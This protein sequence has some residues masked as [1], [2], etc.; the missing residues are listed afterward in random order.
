MSG[1]FYFSMLSVLLCLTSASAQSLPAEAHPSLLLSPEDIPLLKERITRAP[2]DTWWQTVLTRSQNGLAADAP[3]RSKARLAKSMAFTYLMTDENTW[4]EQALALMQNTQFPPR[5]GDMGQPHNEGELVAHYALAYDMLHSYAEANN[6]TAL[7]AVREILAEEAA[8]LEKGIVI[9]EVNL[10]LTTLKIRLHETPHLGN[11]HIRAYAGLGLAAL[12]LSEHEDAQAWAD[13]AFDLV[14][15]S[16]DYQIEEVDGGYAEGPF[17]SRYSADVYLPYMF[18]LKR[19]QGIDLFAGEKMKAMHQWSLNLR[20]PDGR[21]PNIDDSHIDDFYGHYLASVADNGGEYRWDWEHNA[22]GLY[23]RQF[24]E[25]DAIVLFDDQ[26]AATEPTREPTIFMPGAGDAVFRS[27]W[28]ETGT[29]M[30][31]RGENGVA[32]RR[33][34]SHEHPDETSF[35]LHA[36][37]EMLAL[38]AGYINFA[39]HAKVNKGSNHNVVLVDG[40][41][42]PLFTAFGEAIGGGNDA[43]IE[44]SF[45]SGNGDYAEVRAAYQNVD[46]RRR[47]FFVGKEYFLIA[48]HMSASEEH[49]YEWRLHGNGGGSSGGTYSRDGNLAR[50]TRDNAELIAYVPEREGRSFAE[51]DTIHSFAVGQELTH[52]ALLVQQRG[53]GGHYLAALFPRAIGNDAANAPA[54]GTLETVGG[55]GLAVRVVEGGPIADIAWVKDADADTVAISGYLS[56]GAFGWVRGGTED[57]ELFYLVQDGTHL[58][59]AIFSDPET[60]IFSA[61]ETIDLSLHT[62][63][64]RITGFVRG[65]GTG[66]ELTLPI[67]EHTLGSLAFGGEVLSTSE[68]DGFLTLA[69]AGA[70]ELNLTLVIREQAPPEPLFLSIADLVGEFGPYL[71]MNGRERLFIT[72]QNGLSAHIPERAAQSRADNICRLNGRAEATDWLAMPSL[73]RTEPM[74]TMVTD[75][76][77]EVHNSRAQLEV[78]SRGRQIGPTKFFSIT[79]SAEPFSIGKRVAHQ[80]TSNFSLDPAYPNPFNS[81]VIIRFFI[82]HPAAVSV[83]VYN[84]SGQKIRTLETSFFDGGSYHFV[85]D[86]LN[87]RGNS[88]ATGLYFVRLQAGAFQAVQKVTLLR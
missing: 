70:G 59:D 83:T 49:D 27:N 39:N 55:E 26:I 40:Q 87:D 73:S 30:L 28:S 32:R 16:L 7:A 67:G 58:S 12:A 5:G 31:L 51:V 74:L 56:D 20:M 47:V 35:I 52:T 43:F 11:W 72:F 23:V 17:Y 62:T 50:W 82:A 9:Q 36:G 76:R 33:G 84:I 64:E 38:D 65:P 2:Y 86:S 34:L 54:F 45:I 22:N 57:R 71:A 37:G 14:T 77:L 24:S 25:M 61:N 69:L 66:Y 15:R 46:F 60:P 48:D 79:C 19:R 68:S 21:R 81:E 53:R 4:A 1:R 75:T 8:R 6:P 3:E 18:A 44:E 10:G 63:P 78:T 85:W 80:S 29:Y 13:R 42:P 41:G 88:V